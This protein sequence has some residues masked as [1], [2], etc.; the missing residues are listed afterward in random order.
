MGYVAVSGLKCRY[1]R[2]IK[3]TA[4]SKFPGSTPSTVI[5]QLQVTMVGFNSVKVSSILQGVVQVIQSNSGR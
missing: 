3:V 1:T 5:R 4:M 2:I